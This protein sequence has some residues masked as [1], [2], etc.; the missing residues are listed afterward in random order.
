MFTI[1][2][3]S[4]VPFVSFIIHILYKE[5]AIE[6]LTEMISDQETVVT[7]R[8]GTDAITFA[9]MAVD[10]AAD[11][12]AENVVLLDLRRVSSVTD[13]FVICSGAVDR[14]LDGIS[15]N[16]QDVMR[17]EYKLKARHVEGNGETGWVLIDYIDVVIHIFTPTVRA[18]YNL[19]GLWSAAPVLL[20]MQ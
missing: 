14:Q 13:Y 8:P 5:H 11:K 9:R 12:K 3:I 19:E 7:P 15:A 2:A 18:Y 1:R 6:Q 17:K 16:V 20:R 10:A 4:S